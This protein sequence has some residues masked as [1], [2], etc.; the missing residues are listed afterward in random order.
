MPHRAAVEIIHVPAVTGI[1]RHRPPMSFF[2]SKEWCEPEWL[3][4][5]AARNRAH[6]KKAWVKMWNTAG[7]Q[8][9]TPRPSIMYPSCDTVE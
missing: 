6:L 9:P 5:P 1:L 3:T 8:A 7:S 4:D 2:M